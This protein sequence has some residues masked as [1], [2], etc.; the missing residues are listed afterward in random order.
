MTNQ[1]NSYNG[2]TNY[3]TWRV[4][5]DGMTLEYFTDSFSR[6]YGD[7]KE[8]PADVG[9][10]I[11]EHVK[12]I[13]DEAPDGLVKDYANAFISDVNWYEIAGHLIENEQAA[14]A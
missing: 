9:E 7:D 4:K 5:V 1:I 12:S 6:A 10:S 14:A 3:A 2:W 8:S 11:E 13:M